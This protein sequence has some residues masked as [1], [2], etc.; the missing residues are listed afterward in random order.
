MTAQTSERCFQSQQSS[1]KLTS[2]EILLRVHPVLVIS[3]PAVVP[4]GRETM[5][6][7]HEARKVAGY[8]MKL[9]DHKGAAQRP[10]RSDISSCEPT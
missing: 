3:G 9:L 10:P 5:V 7:S 4:R 2:E 1:E 6:A 8:G